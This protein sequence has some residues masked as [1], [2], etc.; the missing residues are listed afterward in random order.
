MTTNTSYIATG[1]PT[2][3][4]VSVSGQFF[5]QPMWPNTVKPS[6]HRGGGAAV[7]A[8]GDAGID[9]ARRPRRIPL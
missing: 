9:L 3:A 2:A 6:S 1:E 7:A 4:F 5:S 8:R